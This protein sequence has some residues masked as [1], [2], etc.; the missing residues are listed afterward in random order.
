MN[1]LIRDLDLPARAD[2]RQLLE[3]DLARIQRHQAE[4]LRIEPRVGFF[5]PSY[6]AV[7]L[8][9]WSW[10]HFQ[11]GRRTMARLYWHLNL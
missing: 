4:V 11:H 9:R 6:L 10:F 1:M 3:R 5:T 2:I 7:R 8:H